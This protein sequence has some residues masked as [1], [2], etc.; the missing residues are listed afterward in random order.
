MLPI[1]SHVL[2]CLPSLRRLVGQESGQGLIEYGLLAAL[3]ALVAIGAV[4][5]VGGQVNASLW[6]PLAASF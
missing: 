2:S 4:T 3:I 6:E 5:S 1:A